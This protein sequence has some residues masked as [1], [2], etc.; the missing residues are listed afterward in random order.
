MAAE[1]FEVRPVLWISIGFNANPD[2]DPGSD[3]QNLLNLQMKIN[4]YFFDKNI[5]YLSL[6]FPL[7][8]PQPSKEIIQ[9]FTYFY[10]CGSHL[11]FW[12]RI[13]IQPTKINAD[14]CGSGSTPVKTDDWNCSP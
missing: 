13:L 1:R 11:P 12:I 7:K 3:D 2:L 6:S 14:P 4:C 5:I 10:F 9:L 8:P